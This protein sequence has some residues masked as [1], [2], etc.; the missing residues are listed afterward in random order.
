MHDT[1][2]RVQRLH[3][4]I[5]VGAQALPAGAVAGFRVFILVARP[6]QQA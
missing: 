3:Y 6:P 1:P 5:G 4:D 2:R